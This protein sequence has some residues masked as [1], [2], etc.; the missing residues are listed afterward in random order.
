MSLGTFTAEQ[1]TEFVGN[2]AIE[3]PKGAKD[4]EIVCPASMRSLTC[5][6]STRGGTRLKLVDGIVSSR[7]KRVFCFNSSLYES[8]T[9]QDTENTRN[10]TSEGRVDDRANQGWEL[11]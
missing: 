5:P 6:F 11:T 3:L 1:R 9:R 10:H 7:D 8:Y 4:A 2:M